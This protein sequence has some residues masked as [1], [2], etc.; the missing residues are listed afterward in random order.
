MTKVSDTM[1]IKDYAPSKAPEKAAEGAVD[2][3]AEYKA[4]GQEA[5]LSLVVRETDIN[6]VLFLL[7]KDSNL[8]IVADKDVKGPV[9]VNIKNKGIFEIL[10]AV[11]KPL[12]YTVFVEDGVIRVT[13]P[14]LVSKMFHINYIRGSR[15]S[16]SSMNASI[17]S[18][19]QSSGQQPGTQVVAVGS[20]GSAGTY[21][22]SG[23]A[24]VT[25]T[26][27]DK[28]SFWRELAG[29]LEVLIFGTSGAGGE[30]SFSK[31]DKTGKKLV[32]NYQSG[33]VFVTDYSDNM[34][35]IEDFLADL[36]DTVRRQV[37]IQAHIVEVSLNDDYSLGLD[38]VALAGSGIG[39]GGQLIKFSQHLVPNPPTGVFQV[40]ITDK[41]VR[42]LLDAMKEQGNLNILSSPR[43][44]AI[45]NQK[46]LIKLT[47]Q[48]VSWITNTIIVPGSNGNITQTSNTP[49]IDEVGIFLDVTPQIDGEGLITMQI[50]PSVSEITSISE[51]PD[52]SSNMPV[53]DIREVDTLVHA[54]TGQT[55]V[56][57]GLIKDKILESKR[58]V[59]L[60]GD[61]PVL[62][63]L[64][65]QVKQEK[66]KTELVIL[67]TP[68]ILN[69]QYIS[70]MSRESE[71][72]L[73]RMGRKFQ[74]VPQLDVR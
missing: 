38:W 3:K 11:T 19:T 40:K 20:A 26:T 66:T 54:R 74:P 15:N 50:H 31:A 49:Q 12:G 32:I 25:I 65:S 39:A 27:E 18:S 13:G 73:L 60:L 22:G 67:L 14:K 6:D 4:Q 24:G 21:R 58:Q 62:G 59:P 44:S 47:T 23:N 43:I 9:T 57:A 53:I 30:S 70:E 51:S 72:R 28:S 33:L 46:A 29:A 7:S 34:K 64:F 37:M 17:S 10:H 52:G 8:P 45:N 41:D 61:I 68:Y 1:A 42:A 2:R 55:V 71:E 48:E 69:E 36:Q 16:S 35:N 56:I 5:K 63:N